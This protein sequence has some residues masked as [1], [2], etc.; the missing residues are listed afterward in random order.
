MAKLNIGIHKAIGRRLHLL[1]D[2]IVDQGVPDRLAAIV[3]SAYS[4][5]ITLEAESPTVM[6]ASALAV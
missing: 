4:D 1:Y 5:P 3:T 6:S 2:G